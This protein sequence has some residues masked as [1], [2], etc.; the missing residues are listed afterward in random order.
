MTMSEPSTDGQPRPTPLPC[1]SC[2]QDETDQMP[3]WEPPTAYSDGSPPDYLGCVECNT[4]LP[5]DESWPP[6]S[7]SS[8]E[9][10]R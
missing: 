3:V 10:D 5:Y 1:P 4:M 9:A 8:T 2:G 6:S 7:P